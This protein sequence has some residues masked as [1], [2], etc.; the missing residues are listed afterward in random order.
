M[1]APVDLDLLAVADG[2]RHEIVLKEEPR[3]LV[4]EGQ[5]RDFS[6]LETGGRSDRRIDGAA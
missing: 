3:G 4:R 6:L 5:G 2:D 1:D